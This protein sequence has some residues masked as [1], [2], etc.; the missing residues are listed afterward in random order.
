LHFLEGLVLLAVQG[1]PIMESPHFQ[2]ALIGLSLLATQAAL[3]LLFEKG[4]ATARTAHAVL[5]TSTM[6]VLLWHATNG[7]NLG[8][9][10]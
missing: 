3:P 5:G 4:G 10:F 1:K 8:L 6:G 2:S 9:S 7:L